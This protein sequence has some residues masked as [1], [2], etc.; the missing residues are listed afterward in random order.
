MNYKDLQNISELSQ[1]I[2][3]ESASEEHDVMNR[4]PYASPYLQEERAPGVKPYKPGPTQADIRAGEKK[5]ANKKAE[6]GKDK[7]GYGPEEKFKD[8]KDRATP[9]ST[10]KR[11]GGETE[12]VSQRMDREKPY[13]KRMTGQMAREYG[14]RHAAEVTRVVK[15][16]GE[17][18][19]VTY[20]R[21]GREEEKPKAKARLSREI[22]R[23][24]EQNE[25]FDLYDLVLAH[26]L[27][28]GYAETP[29]AAEAIMVNMSEEWRESICEEVL[30]E[31]RKPS[32][33]D[34]LLQRAGLPTS[35]NQAAQYANETPKETEER[36]R[37]VDQRNK[38]TSLSADILDSG[39]MSRRRKRTQKE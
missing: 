20:P 31:S 30:D 35:L 32:S 3:T 37:R 39:Q 15:G 9:T 13:G 34:L 24:G 33:Y 16:A 6:A 14:S 36:M 21:K 12:T 22:I 25:G 26:L 2:L 5:A 23:K 38:K 7:P 4:W 8:W 17:P 11:K 27:D 10:L 18:Q 1:Q 29:E 19:A 28:E